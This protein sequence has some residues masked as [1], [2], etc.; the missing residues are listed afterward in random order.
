MRV[1][2]DLSATRRAIIHARIKHG[3]PEGASDA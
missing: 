1:I 3:Y 2:R